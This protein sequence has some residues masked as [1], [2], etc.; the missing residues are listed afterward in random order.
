LV[1]QAVVVFGVA[2][3]VWIIGGDTYKEG[4]FLYKH[5]FILSAGV[6]G[7]AIVAA[8]YLADWLIWRDLRKNSNNYGEAL[9]KAE[10]FTSRD[11][12]P[13]LGWRTL[14]TSFVTV[15]I[16]APLQLLILPAILALF[17]PPHLLKHFVIAGFLASYFVLLMGGIDTRLDTMWRLLQ[18]FLFR[19]GALL[20]SLT[21]I[22]IAAARFF[23]FTY[24]TTVFDTAEGLVITLMLLNVYVLFWWYD[25]WVNRLLAQELLRIIKPDEV[26]AAQIPYLIESSYKATSVPIDNRVLQI[27]GESR[28]VA[29][30]DIPNGKDGPYFQ[31]YP[32]DKL[33]E[34]LAIDGAP[35]GKATPS[36]SLIA[37]RIFYHKCLAGILLVG[38]AW[39]VGWHIHT[40]IQEAQLTV[41]N[42]T[43]PTLQLANLLVDRDRQLEKRPAL[44]IAASGGG[45]RAAL[46]TAAVIEG[47]ENIKLARDVI[48]GSGVSG[49]GAA[50]AYFAGK[51][52]ELVGSQGKA[53]DGFFAKM[54]QAFIKDVLNGSLEWRIVSRYRLGQ[55]LYESFMRRWELPEDRNKLSEVK[56]F[57]LILNTAVAGKFQCDP[58]SEECLRLSLIEAEHRFRKKMTSTELAGSRLILTNLNLAR[59]ADFMP[60]IRETGGPTGLPVLVV[61]DAVTR[62]E[63]AAALNAN[64][65]P[66]FSNAAV[67]VAKRSRYWVTDGGAADNRGIEMLLYALRQTLESPSQLQDLAS[68]ERLP[69]ITVVV[70][71][72]S[73]FSIAFHQ[74]RGL[75][76]V[77]GAGKQ[78]ASLLVAEQLR[79]IRALYEQN[80]CPENFRFVYL[81][82]PLCLRESGS[83]GTHWM[84][85]PT[86]KIQSGSGESRTLSG[87][88]MIQLLRVLHGNGQSDQ[89]SHSAQAVLDWARKDEGWISGARELGLAP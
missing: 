52:P 64:F 76:T 40:G 19:G 72:A 35:G 12:L 41:D 18:S 16:G 31:A 88:E 10:L 28:F 60:S 79:S 53:W 1:M 50:L 70:A 61:D 65:P 9:T 27:H 20:V 11:R 68:G 48:M 87:D 77:A 85:Q 75:S 17:A 4:V 74:D 46:Y 45:T 13:S 30:R 66:V 51:R 44:V 2:G 5:F 80:G 69:K 54:K 34:S 56:D 84:L 24:V 23:D 33:F 21:V 59:G 8:G 73:A 58:T 15:I 89:L 81:P 62:L 6:V 26:S 67:D 37:K 43:R 83:F 14:F 22:A 57:G 49:G 7:G 38:L 86:I 42:S 3:T 47:L 36:P 39:L 71:D 32:M 29:I 55:L 78:F 82:M 63:A 25:Y